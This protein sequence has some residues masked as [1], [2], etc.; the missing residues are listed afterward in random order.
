V[1]SIV[2]L[3]NASL[4]A[5]A[6]SRIASCSDQA[7]KD[8]TSKR[9]D[10]GGVTWGPLTRVV[11]GAA[12][13]FTAR[14]PYAVV[15]TTGA[16]LLNYVDTTHAASWTNWQIRS[17]DAGATWT[18]PARVAGLGKWEGVLMGP[19]T[20]IVL[21]RHSHNS[22]APGRIVGCGA[23]GYQAGHAM[24]MP[25]WTSD[26]DGAS[27]QLAASPAGGAFAGLQECQVVELA[28]GTVVVNARNALRRGK[29][30]CKC[31][32][33]AASH[34]GGKNWAPYTFADALVEPVCSAG[35]INHGGALF[36]SNPA[37]AT[38]RVAM[39]LKRSDDS[40]ATWAP[41]AELWSGPSAYSCATPVS[42]TEVGVMYENGVKDS[43]EKLT[44]AVVDVSQ[45]DD[46]DMHPG[47]AH[48]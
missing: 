18:A 8:I 45:T 14:N 26:D 1:P 42:A 23:T 40:G 36:F 35:L 4:V 28:N 19:G 13:N 7:P 3:P 44:F 33:V 24:L 21:G 29:G 46:V 31:R 11:T 41:V 47:A 27:Y 6:E 38:A 30:Q 48:P 2:Q 5:V 20:A 12:S 43:Y 22:P 32:A 34:D 16:I 37:S 39:T 15:D 17:A 25:L 9:S 10:D